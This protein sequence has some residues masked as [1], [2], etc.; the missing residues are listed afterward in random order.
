[1]YLIASVIYDILCNPIS[2][3]ELPAYIT[4]FSRLKKIL[5]AFESMRSLTQMNG[6]SS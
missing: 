6:N 2:I 5:K 3:L 4:I 1:M